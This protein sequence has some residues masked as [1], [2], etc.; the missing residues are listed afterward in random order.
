[1]L[2]Y[3]IFNVKK[4]V[5][6]MLK[7]TYRRKC[8]WGRHMLTSGE[9]IITFYKLRTLPLFVVF[10]HA[11]FCHTCIQKLSKFSHAIREYYVRAY[12]FTMAPSSLQLVWLTTY[13]C[14]VQRVEGW[15]LLK[16]V[17]SFLLLLIFIILFVEFYSL[18]SFFFYFYKMLKLHLYI[19][20]TLYRCIHR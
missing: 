19:L 5:L 18:W 8:C 7:S 6:I 3:F 9:V 15:G 1:M 10:C 16:K 13:W 17:I 12:D 14:A 4:Y 2:L 11:C 20:Y